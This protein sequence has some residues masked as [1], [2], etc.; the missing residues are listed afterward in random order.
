MLIR[1]RYEGCSGHTAKATLLRIMNYGV[2]TQILFFLI[3]TC[4]TFAPY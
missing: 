2:D 4:Q 3:L 1:G